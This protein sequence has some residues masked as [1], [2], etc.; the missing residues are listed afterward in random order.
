MRD[1]E[2][3]PGPPEAL[4]L[5]EAQHLDNAGLFV[6]GVVDAPRPLNVYVTGSSAFHLRDKTRESLAGRAVRVLLLPLSMSELLAHVGGAWTAASASTILERQLLFG[7]Y[8]EV[9]L[10]GDEI[11][12]LLD[13]VE[14]FVMRDASDLYRIQRPA[15]FRTLIKLAALQ[16]G[17]LVNLSEWAAL[18]GLS[19]N[20]VSAYISVMEESWVARR[21]YLFHGGKRAEFT[22]T[23]KIYFLD[24]GLRNRLLNNFSP[25]PD[26]TDRGALFENWVF[27]ELMKNLVYPDDLR[28]WR[29][30]G[31]AEVDFVLHQPGT[32]P[33]AIEAKL[34]PRLGRLSRGARS[35]LDSYRP[36]VFVTVSPDLEGDKEILGIRCLWVR[37][38][39]LPAA[40]PTRFREV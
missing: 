17:G 30:R 11:M 32:P 24:N 29:T 31:G 23:P 18:T 6:K 16:I 26:R 5:D 34:N 36:E 33:V 27:G 7:A 37:P 13:L 25:L 12:R 20:T 15:A 21:L 39:Q 40:I 14:A 38:E 2:S 4:F 28:Y 10:K 1:F 9:Y 22:K 19:V 35:F 8:P 3:L